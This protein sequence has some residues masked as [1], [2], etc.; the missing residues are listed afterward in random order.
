MTFVIRNSFLELIE[1]CAEPTPVGS[2]KRSNSVPKDCKFKITGED[3]FSLLTEDSTV[4]SDT[5]PAGFSDSDALASS[6]DDMHSC[7]DGE[8]ASLASLSDHE[9]EVELQELKVCAGEVARVSAAPSRPVR[10]RWADEVLEM[11]TPEASQDLWCLRVAEEEVTE[12]SQD[13]MVSV[14]EETPLEPVE[15]QKARSSW[16]DW[17]PKV[18]L[19]AERRSLR[20]TKSGG[21]GMA[22]LNALDLCVAKSRPK[23]ASKV[24]S[25]SA[26]QAKE[27]VAS[28]GPEASTHAG[29][30]KLEESSEECSD[31]AVSEC[32]AVG[33]DE[34]YFQ[35][36]DECSSRSKI[37]IQLCVLMPE[38]ALATPP[39]ETKLKATAATFMPLS[40]GIGEAAMVIAAAQ[41]ALGVC[42]QVFGVERCDGTMGTITTLSAQVQDGPS[43][44]A[45]ASQS[46]LEAAKAAL[47]ATAS[48][49]Q[50]VYV[51]GYL[52]EY[53]FEDFEDGTGFAASLGFV[54]RAQED[55]ACWDTFQKGFCPRRT[56]CR[57]CHPAQSDLVRVHV[58]LK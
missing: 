41:M 40:C 29:S 10:A 15:E 33:P 7:V 32:C 30:A 58:S 37:P 11:A 24:A 6:E 8:E 28:E 52:T 4:A 12:A 44:A 55:T 56:T 36:D 54:T 38:D 9:H 43:P 3:P 50:N 26:K 31:A 49:S 53:P 21:G 25:K 47:L 22:R 27:D 16:M 17:S 1:N 2:T 34:A 13:T 57:W 42:P 51:I 18:A 45:E 19:P 14:Q 20:G 23:A 48:L 46:A 5:T 39:V 35:D